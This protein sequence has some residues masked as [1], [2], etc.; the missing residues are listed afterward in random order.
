[1]ATLPAPP[2]RLVFFAFSASSP[3]P[4]AA[5]TL[6][7]SP[8]F[9]LLLGCALGLDAAEAEVVAAS[10]EAA[11]VAAVRRAVNS[12]GRVCYYVD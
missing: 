7:L 4:P 6:C 5:V 3:A 10:E 1:D 11:A 12:E 2:G 8:R 9:G